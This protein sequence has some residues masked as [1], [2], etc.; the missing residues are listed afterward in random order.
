M[1]QLNKGFNIVKNIVGSSYIIEIDELSKK[2]QN[3]LII[4]DN[5]H[6]IDAL[7]N[8]L[9]RLYNSKKIVKFPNYGHDDYSSVAI[10]KDIIKD[11][12][13]CLIE[14]LLNTENRIIITTYKSIF[15]KIPNLNEIS[16]SWKKIDKN[17]SY[18]ELIDALR[19]F[20]YEKTSKVVEPGQYR[21]S[22]SIIDFF[23]ISS[24]DPLRVN[25]FEDNLESLKIFSST[26]QLTKHEIDAGVLSSGSVYH[27][28]Q[29]NIDFYK[30]NVKNYFDSEYIE[31]I[32]YEKMVSND[33]KNYIHN[34]IPILFKD[35]KS[36]IS[37]LDNDSVC[38]MNKNLR[39]EY[40]DFRNTLNKIYD[41]EILN[42]YLIK[43]DELIISD[44][45]FEHIINNNYLY[46]ASDY[47]KDKNFYKSSYTTLPSL[48]INYNYKNP[49]INL[50]KVILN[51]KY[52]FIFFIKRNDN[53][54]TLT[55]YLERQ[56]IE[57]Y[58]T[59]KII[60]SGKKIQI[61][62]EH[63][64]EGFVDN[65]KRVI[66]VSSNDLFG[67]IKTRLSSK[68]IL[69]TSVI[70]HL[71]QIKFNDYIVHQEHGI[72]RY[73]G[74]EI[75][76]IENKVTEL[77]KIEYADN[78]NLYI[79]ITS[80]SLIQ[81]YIGNTGINTKLSELG[82]D[83]WLKVKQRAKKK[84]EDIAAELLTIQA[85]RELNKG[86]KFNLNAHEYG[87]FCNLFPYVE[88]D[89]QLN[90]INQ[91]IEDMC[92]FKAMDRVI[93][94]DVGFGKTEV[95]LRAAFVA[96]NNNKQVVVIVPTTVLAKQHYDTFSKRFINY[97]IKIELMTRAISQKEKLGVKN[98]LL[99]SETNIVI[100]THA[101]LN[102]EIKYANLG[103]LIIDEEH[104]FGVKHKESIKNIKN[105]IDVLTLTATPIPRTL[106]TAL[107]EIKDM[108]II[109]TPPIGRKNIQTNIINKSENEIREYIDREITRGGQVLYIHNRIE[110]MGDEISYLR[111][112][113]SNYKIDSVHG[114]MTTHQIQKVM[115]SFLSEKINILICTSIIESGLD[116][117]NV[118]TIIINNAQNFGLSQLHQIR[119]RVGRS[120][121][122]A[123]AGIIIGD[124]KKLTNEGQ[125][126]I[127]AFVNTNSLAGGLD[128][129]SHDLEIRGAGELLGEEQSGQIIEIGYGMYT[130]MLSRAV[131]QL[132]N[133]DDKDDTV[134]VEIDAYESTL[135]P[136][137]YI[138]DIFQRLDFYKDISSATN[139]HDI[140]QIMTRLIDI[141]GPIPDHLLNL[142][143]LTRVKITG[144]ALGAQRIKINRDNV[145]IVLNEENSIDTQILVN[146][147]TDSKRIKI[148]NN[149]QIKYVI[150]SDGDFSDVCSEIIK[151]I[152]EIT[153]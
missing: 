94:G 128:I 108:S 152:S 12:Y 138:E 71:T 10:D 151:V 100:G 78:N 146:K 131:N 31:D 29:K 139:D 88:T 18:N 121:R 61:I 132:K 80:L 147:Y 72:G 90:S 47:T 83:R 6:Q 13:E 39:E 26:T 27:L 135:I 119:G 115:N 126:R 142:L 43:P 101:L 63:I 102:K 105:N 9:S 38:F 55:D 134:Q 7:Y 130:S 56:D 116:M 127:D 67:L 48:A 149:N 5:N 19:S 136:Q 21:V 85:Q 144:N 34:L 35:T 111:A 91:V 123:Y 14:L 58:E 49:F 109:N 2:Y 24:H 141:F 41:S 70:D 37:L 22:G 30:T 93:C 60:S 53:F 74:L 143:D 59:D 79:P 114:R 81:K 137:D 65:N 122:Q 97:D 50:E 57:F 117:A 140:N 16:R 84:I 44:N 103:L 11:R 52:N 66:Y 77:V 42:R 129:A 148:I 145:V 107:S 150:E 64:N 95:I 124:Q 96:I 1:K 40:D 99:N 33:S 125:K 118:N 104:K 106:N 46:L 87:K 54:K 133:I 76:N 4:L 75:M 36:L 113:N 45:D 23:S 32:E 110:T 86:Y 69:K 73:K 17:I 68:E 51:S 3:T 62:R 20:N 89:D 153:C 120:A 82:T 112:I 25:F 28:D 92:S 98:N 15:Y 8:E